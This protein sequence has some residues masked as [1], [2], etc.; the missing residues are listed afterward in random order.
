[1][2][3]CIHYIFFSVILFSCT[4]DSDPYIDNLE[5]QLPIVLHE[6][7][8]EFDG[9]E[10][11]SYGQDLK[12]KVTETTDAHVKHMEIIAR[13]EDSTVLKIY[14]Q[15]LWAD[16]EGT[17]MELIEYPSNPDS[18]ECFD[19]GFLV[20]CTVGA[21]VLE[22]AEGLTYEPTQTFGSVHITACDDAQQHTSGSFSL[23][24]TLDGSEEKLI[25]GTF[26]TVDYSY[27]N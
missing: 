16:G 10:Y 6:V 21:C 25:T 1:M 22:T 20:I 8:W 4:N 23:P 17:C 14:A 3:K 27:S 18:T 19:D 15:N 11:R 5:A 7:S 12:A 24:L 2:S 9:K 13:T 26:F